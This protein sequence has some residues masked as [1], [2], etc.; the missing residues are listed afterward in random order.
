MQGKEERSG[1]LDARETF[2]QLWAAATASIAADSPL[3][4]GKLIDSQLH[5]VPQTAGSSASEVGLTVMSQLPVTQV[6]SNFNL[7]RFR[8]HE[9][10]VPFQVWSL[11]CPLIRCN[12]RDLAERLNIFCQSLQQERSCTRFTMR[13]KQLTSF[14]HWII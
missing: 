2:G 11:I 6:L 5:F 1:G 4:P 13:Q 12:S 7:M 14:A 9:Q 8:C 3:K 10:Q